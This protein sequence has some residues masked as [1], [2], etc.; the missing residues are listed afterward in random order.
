MMNLLVDIYTQTETTMNA[1][2]RETETLLQADWLAS[3]ARVSGS[4]RYMAMGA[5]VSLD[6]GMLVPW[7]DG[8][9]E[10][11][12]L[13]NVRTREGTALG[14]PAT[15]YKVKFVKPG[16]RRGHME[17]DLEALK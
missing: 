14:D 3:W 2:P 1:A 11:C 16:A 12:V 8:L 17:L 7:L 13:R 4:R 6:A 15:G 5:G 10:F 9:N